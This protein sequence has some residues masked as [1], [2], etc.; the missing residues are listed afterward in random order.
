MEYVL[1]DLN[2]SLSKH[3][4][5]FALA[6]TGLPQLVLFALSTYSNAPCPPVRRSNFGDYKLK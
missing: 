6:D 1:V 3:F 5:V 2:L 4:F